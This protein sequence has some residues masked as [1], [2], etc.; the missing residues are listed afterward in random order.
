[1]SSTALCGSILSAAKPI[2]ARMQI[3][4][5]ITRVT[6]NS[7]FLS[8]G[9]ALASEMLTDLPAE[10]PVTDVPERGVSGGPLVPPAYPVLEPEACAAASSAAACPEAAACTRLEPVSR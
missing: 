8:A 1:M 7:R 3:I 6:R 2:A 4:A 9:V 5:G 10:D